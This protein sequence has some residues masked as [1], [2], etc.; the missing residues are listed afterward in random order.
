MTFIYELDPYSLLKIYRMCENE[1]PTSRFR[2]LSS[3][4]HIQTDT[5]TDD[6]EIIYHAASWVVNTNSLIT[7]MEVCSVSILAD[8]YLSVILP[9]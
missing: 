5:Q 8:E 1:L 7:T 3:D 6:A 9:N 2:N 4:R